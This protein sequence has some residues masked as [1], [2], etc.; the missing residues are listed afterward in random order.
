[1]T[2][3]TARIR[4]LFVDYFKQNRHEVLKS[5]SLIAHGD[6]SLLFTNAGTRLF[7]VH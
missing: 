6:D 2:L 1:M 5:A 7:I 3:T 4:Q